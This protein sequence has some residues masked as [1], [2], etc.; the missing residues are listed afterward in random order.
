MQKF[1]IDITSCDKRDIDHVGR[2]A[3]EFGE[4]SRIDIP[5]APGFVITTHSFEEFLKANKLYSTSTTEEKI[6]HAP[7]PKEIVS[8]IYKSYNE[9][10]DLFKE[11]T[12]IVSPSSAFGNF[13]YI[14]HGVYYEVR[15]DANLILKI[16]EIWSKQFS[17]ISLLE[18]KAHDF[19]NISR[20]DIAVVIQKKID[21]SK[22]GTMFTEDPITSD[23]S[24]IVIE[25]S[26]FAHSHY[27]VSRR[28]LKLIFKSHQSHVRKSQMI[29]HEQ[30][31]NLANLGIKLQKHFYFPQEIKFSI[32]KNIIYI[33][34][35]KPMTHSIPQPSVKL[36]HMPLLHYTARRP[37]QSKRDILLKGI[38]TFPGITTGPVRVFKNYK[39]IHYVNPSE[40]LVVP[41][42]EKDQF[43]LIKKAKALITEK[44]ALS[45]HDKM[46][47]GKI[48]GKPIIQGAKS[49][50]SI[51]HTGT[52][53]TLNG[54]NGEIHKGGL[55]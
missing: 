36:R 24:K 43:L 9:L 2:Y 8:Q 39:A 23:R 42:I 35:T 50:T 49:A 40:I 1:V 41:K 16:K 13:V 34:E 18:T 53:V 4:L 37:K 52:V 10:S 46:I 25:Q 7:F 32:D 44:M 55:N 27:V 6:M 17:K 28:D 48:V 3:A 51:L 14:H 30:I 45:D 5:I 15:G 21:L 29:S 22:S 11:S 20:L 33:L 47:Y 31:L 12:V 19:N 38:C 26:G 54:E